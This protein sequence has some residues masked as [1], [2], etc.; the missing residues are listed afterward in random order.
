V[1]KG[2]VE[3]MLTAG[4]VKQ[5]ALLLANHIAD[6]SHG[7]KGLLTES[8]FNALSDSFKKSAEIDVYNRYRTMFE[9]VQVYLTTLSQLRLSYLEILGRLDKLILLR[10]ANAEMEDLA[11]HLL[12]LITDKKER[13]KAT[14]IA[15]GFSSTALLRKIE[16]DKD[17]YIE[18]RGMGPTEDPAIESLRAHVQTEQTNL[19]TAIQ[20]IKDYFDETG[21]NVKVF[22]D[23]VRN[24][25]NWAKGKSN[26]GLTSMF[27]LRAAKE[28]DSRAKELMGKNLLEPD[29]EDV[30]VD[31]EQYKKLRRDYLDV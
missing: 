8:E 17:G 21:F 23:F 16:T 24:L 19:K 11:N 2:S 12:E 29:Y 18:V 3:K 9:K 30:Q 27:V 14:K 10:K 20:V 13:A 28:D 25:E 31:Q 15:K 4:S 26:K 6:L 5:R 7:G 1:N 22:K